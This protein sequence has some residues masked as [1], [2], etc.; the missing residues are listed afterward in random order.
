[1]YTEFKEATND[2]AIKSARLSDRKVTSANSLVPSKKQNKS[3]FIDASLKKPN[4]TI[5]S[6]RPISGKRS[7][8]KEQKLM[9][10]YTKLGLSHNVSKA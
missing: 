1:M 10:V 8:S 6:P 4:T 7:G 5:N 2:L 3:I 9:K